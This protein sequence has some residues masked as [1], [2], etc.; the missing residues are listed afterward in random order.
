MPH[1]EV[2]KS[3]AVLRGGLTRLGELAFSLWFATQAGSAE[4][5]WE[6]LRPGGYGLLLASGTVDELIYNEIGNELLL[7]KYVDS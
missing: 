7:I 1:L 5:H 6:C 3:G 4:E 2:G